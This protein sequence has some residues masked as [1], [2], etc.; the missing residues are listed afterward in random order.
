MGV[1]CDFPLAV[2]AI[3]LNLAAGRGGAPAGS[4]IWHPSAALEFK[5]LRGSIQ[6]SQRSG[7]NATVCSCMLDTED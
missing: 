6:L 5:P 2:V 1:T 3:D 7:I 4:G